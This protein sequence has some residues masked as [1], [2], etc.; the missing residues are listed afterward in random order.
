MFGILR[1]HRFFDLF[2][3]SRKSGFAIK[4]NRFLMIL[5]CCCQCHGGVHYAHQMNSMQRHS[6]HSERLRWQLRRRQRSSN[7]RA[8]LRISIEARSGGLARTHVLRPSRT[9]SGRRRTSRRRR[10]RPTSDRGHRTVAMGILDGLSADYV[11]GGPGLAVLAQGPTRAWPR[12]RANP[13]L[14]GGPRICF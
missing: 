11:G 4:A 6:H 2:P 14:K 12:V 5:L 13:G 7:I 9:T 10:R 8:L 3:K 1:L